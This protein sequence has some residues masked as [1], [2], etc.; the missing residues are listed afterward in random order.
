MKKYTLP[1][2]LLVGLS[3]QVFSQ[4][5]WVEPENPDVTKPIR[6]Y[7][8]L[9]KATAATADA[10]KANPAGPFYIWTW[11]P[12]ELTRADTL[13]NGTGDKPWKSSNDRLIMVKDSVKGSNVWYY[14]T[15]PTLFYNC[16]ANTVYAKGISFLVKPKDGGGYGDPDVKTEDFNVVINP[17]KLDRGILYS[18]PQT[19]Y[20]DEITSLVY[21]NPL[22]TKTTMQHLN[23]GDV[24]MHMV[25]TV[26]DTATQNTTTLE[27]AKF[28]QVQNNSELKMVKMSDG[29]FK[30]TM[31]PRRYFNITN[32][33]EVLVDITITVRKTIW[34]TSDD[35]TNEKS[36]LKYGCQ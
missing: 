32:P 30:I 28:L 16:D 17:P 31:I 6:I 33:K 21:D 5:A 7:C 24:Y 26:K 4:T 12:T 34:N 18:I 11:N 27:P 36:K 29:R 23:D 13:Q 25:A 1:L 10:M 2:L 9:S 8:D 35:Q 19:M 22:E 14:E 15:T 20:E 3:P